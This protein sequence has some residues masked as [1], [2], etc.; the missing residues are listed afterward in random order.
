MTI[1][2]KILSY[3]AGESESLP[4]V[5]TELERLLAKIAEEGGGGGGGANVLT[6]YLGNK[7]SNAWAYKNPECTEEYTSYD[8]AKAAINA[9]SILKLKAE[10]DNFVY[11]VA[12]GAHIEDNRE[13]VAVASLNDESVDTIYLWYRYTGPGDPIV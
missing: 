5:N 3:M 9:A 4:P 10:D 2:E 1:V 8:E 12:A 11:P 6:L 13:F 7:G